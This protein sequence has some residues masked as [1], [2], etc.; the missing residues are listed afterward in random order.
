MAGRL[1]KVLDRLTFRRALTR[2]A[3]A[4][5]EA[6]SMGLEAL[7][8]LRTRARQ[9]RRELD[10][11]IHQAEYRLALPVIAAAATGSPAEQRPAMIT[12]L[13]GP[14]CP[15]LGSMQ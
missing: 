9:M 10:R 1:D 8:A 11:V 6:P 7:R 14:S 4:A 15:A 2:W 13:S 3:S 12:A 5:E